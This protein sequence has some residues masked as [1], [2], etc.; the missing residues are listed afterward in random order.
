MF[1]QKRQSHLA[2]VIL[3]HEALDDR[4]FKR[5]RLAETLPKVVTINRKLRMGI[6]AG[7]SRLSAFA[8]ATYPR[9]QSIR[10]L[11]EECTIEAFLQLTQ[12]QHETLPRSRQLCVP[13]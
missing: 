13:Q 10:R 8:A 11:V 2:K 4:K 3:S 12:R 5:Q 9:C 7:A 1:R 6:D